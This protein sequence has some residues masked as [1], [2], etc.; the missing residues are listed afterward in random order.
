M[1]GGIGTIKSPLGKRAD[2]PGA[3]DREVAPVLKSLVPEN[4]VKIKKEPPGFLQPPQ[5]Y[6]KEGSTP[7]YLAAQEGPVEIVASYNEANNDGPLAVAPLFSSQN[8]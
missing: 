6:L 7:L 8:E 1:I 3:S 2:L 5:T 4:P